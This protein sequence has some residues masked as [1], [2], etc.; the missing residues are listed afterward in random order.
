MDDLVGKTLGQYEIRKL[1][2]K[3][4][5]S[6]VYLAYQPSMDRMVA[7][8]LLPP[9]FLHDSTFLTRF[10]QECRVVARLEHLHILPVYDVGSQDGIPFIVMRYLQ[11]GTLADLI[12]KGR[13]DVKEAARLITQIADALDFAHGAGVIHRDMKP[14]NILLD[15]NRNAF[16]AD[17]GIARLTA[18]HASLTGS[19]IIGTPPYIAPEMV[20]KGQEVTYLSD[21]YALGVIAFE[22]VTGRPPYA[23]PDPMKVLMMHVMEPVPS[24]RAFNPSLGVAVD[25]VIRRCLAKTADERYQKASNFARALTEAASM[26]SVTMP[27][28]TEESKGVS[29]GEVNTIRTP[30]PPSGIIMGD[31]GEHAAPTIRPSRSG[32]KEAA[33]KNAT[34]SPPRQ[35]PARAGCASRWWIFALAGLGALGVLFALRGRITT[36]LENRADRQEAGATETSPPANQETPLPV[37]GPSLADMQLAFA[38]NRDG[39]YEIFIING[40]GSGLTQLTSNEAYDFDPTW[41]PDGERILFAS[42][43]SGN[44]EIMVMLSDGNNPMNLTNHPAKDSDPDWSPD[45]GLIAFSSDRDGDFEIYVMRQDGS[46]LQQITFNDRNDYAPSW[47]PD[48]RRLIY[49]SQEGMN[50]M[51]AEIFL[52]DLDGNGQARRITSNDWLDKWPAWAPEGP[53]FAFTSGAGLAAG[54]RAVFLTPIDFNPEKL[55]PGEGKDDDPAWSPDGRFIAYDTDQGS[56]GFFNLFIINIETREVIRLT[57]TLANDVSPAWRPHR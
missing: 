11:G 51:T 19:R 3:G 1:I 21:I 31:T 54:R 27:T 56:D 26:E 29:L 12:A 50:E 14:S 41:S 45:G 40:D 18:Q 53:R 17:F 46:D 23:D 33:K 35:K 42:D 47:A 36:F 9:E 16:L 52:Y 37:A 25:S 13:M 34:P 30:S 15:E 8:K 49:Y 5:M 6:S 43:L 20:H 4:G 2:G 7:I 55:T 44:S 10:Q 24:P 22:M 48:S 38:S 28:P 39:D 57:E 32:T